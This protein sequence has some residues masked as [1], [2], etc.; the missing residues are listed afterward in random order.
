VVSISGQTYHEVKD[1][2]Q[3]SDSAGGY[4][5]C[6]LGHQFPR[7]VLRVTVRFGQKNTIRPG[8][9]KNKELWPLF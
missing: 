4:I 1:A 8:R 6:I 3:C 9:I 7:I 2:T 5:L